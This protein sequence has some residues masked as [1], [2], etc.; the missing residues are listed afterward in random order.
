M[1]LNYV[2]IRDEEREYLLRETKENRKI[3]RKI[4]KN[5]KKKKKAN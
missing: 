4:I 5:L 1:I 3:L 2:K